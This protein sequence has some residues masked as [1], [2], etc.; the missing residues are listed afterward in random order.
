MKKILLSFTFL[1]LVVLAA[2]GN[3]ESIPPTE[4]PV[5]TPVEITTETPSPQVLS[6]NEVESIL[7]A[8]HP[9]PEYHYHPDLDF[10]VD[11]IKFYCF[12]SLSG[13][14]VWVDSITGQQIQRLPDGRDP[15]IFRILQEGFQDRWTF[16]THQ[17]FYQ[18][19]DCRAYLI[20]F[21]SYWL[22]FTAH[23]HVDYGGIDG[24]HHRFYVQLSYSQDSE[25]MVFTISVFDFGIQDQ[26]G[27][28]L[29]PDGWP[30]P[31]PERVLTREQTAARL[32]AFHGAARWYE[33]HP[34][35]D[36]TFDGTLYHGFATHTWADMNYREYGGE[37]GE[38]FVGYIWVNT[39]TGEFE[40]YG[41]PMFPEL[42][43]P[44]FAVFE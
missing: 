1:A 12:R 42:N 2:C 35:R 38:T 27:T 7:N 18:L 29:N 23:G 25:I 43:N 13:R 11:D 36:K 24:E 30:W 19:E 34:E 22:D 9:F 33:E 3:R 21:L 14:Y 44:L 17:G 6:P 26:E 20:V 37:Y 5:E 28:L 31:L 32:R 4:T 8:P 40:S 15:E 39:I 16:P 10:L 41:N